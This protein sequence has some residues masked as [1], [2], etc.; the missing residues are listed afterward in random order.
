[1]LNT[2][3]ITH[4]YYKRRTLKG[5]ITNRLMVFERKILRKIFGPT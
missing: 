2:G 3:L 4:N 5:T 1:M